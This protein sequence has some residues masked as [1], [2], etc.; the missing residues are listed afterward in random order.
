MNH[1]NVIKINVLSGLQT[2][3]PLLFKPEC[4]DGSILYD[5]GTTQRLSTSFY[6]ELVS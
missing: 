1:S 5:K 2:K 6:P 3:Y 4:Q